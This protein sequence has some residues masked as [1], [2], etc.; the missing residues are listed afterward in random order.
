M[1]RI[2][3]TVRKFYCL[4]GVISIIFIIFALNALYHLTIYPTFF[5]L[6]IAILMGIFSYT[7]TKRV[8]SKSIP[9]SS[10]N[11]TNYFNSKRD[12]DL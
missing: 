11:N 12:L 10:K 9:Y 3:H 1:N 2:M 5:G 7:S 4:N 6:L 8:L